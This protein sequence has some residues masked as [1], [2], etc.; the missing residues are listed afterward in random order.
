MPLEEPGVSVGALEMSAKP[1]GLRE[2]VIRHNLELQAS[3]NQPCS[4]S[5]LPRLPG[6]PSS[7]S[8]PPFLP[9]QAGQGPTDTAGR[10]GGC[11]RSFALSRGW[12]G[13]FLQGV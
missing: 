13:T 7:L 11:A 8:G 2:A 6:L 1:E 12:E 10:E 5:A 3:E 4:R 9:L